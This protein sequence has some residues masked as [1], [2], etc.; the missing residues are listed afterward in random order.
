LQRQGLRSLVLDL[1]QNDSGGLREVDHTAGVF[2]PKGSPLYTLRGMESA[3]GQTDRTPAIPQSLPLVVL[4]DADTYWVAEVLAAALS[5]AGRARLV[6]TR[7]ARQGAYGRTYAITGGGMLLIKTGRLIT[8]KG[9][10]LEQTGVSPDI[11]VSLRAADL[12]AGIDPQL[13][14]ALQLAG[15][16]R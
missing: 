8:A 13:A 1:R 9:V 14:R 3:T 16:G 5:E 12:D 11:V 15:Q 4:I 10:L 2:L 7:T 6:G